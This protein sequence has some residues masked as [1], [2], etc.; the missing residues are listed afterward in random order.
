MI[1][2]DLRLSFRE[3]LYDVKV[4]LKFS[5]PREAPQKPL[6]SKISFC[7]LRWVATWSATQ[8]PWRTGQLSRCPSSFWRSSHGI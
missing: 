2:K 4:K 8:R 3:R 6:N 1:E 5:A 7:I